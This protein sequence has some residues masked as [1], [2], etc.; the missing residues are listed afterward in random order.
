L[1][2]AWMEYY[3]PDIGWIACDPLW[4]YFNRIDYLRFNL[5]VGAN[6]FFP[7]NSIISEFDTLFRY[8]S[9]FHDYDYNITITVI[10]SNLAPLDSIPLIFFLFIGI[11]VAALLITVLLI[12]RIRRNKGEY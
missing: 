1:G 6:F 12:I 10:E 3:V 2:H 5:N 9:V 7:P 11:G 8:T 4:D